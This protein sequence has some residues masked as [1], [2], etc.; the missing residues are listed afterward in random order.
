MGKTLEILN[1]PT[2]NST[3]TGVEE[4]QQPGKSAIEQQGNGDRPSEIPFIEV[5]GPRAPVEASVHVPRANVRPAMSSRAHGAAGPASENGTASRDPVGVIYKPPSSHLPAPGT[6]WNRFAPQLITY[7]QPHHPVSEQYRAVLDGMM[8][9]RVG[10]EPPVFLLVSPVAGLGTT[11]VVLNLAIARAAQ[12]G[13]R[14]L[15]VD[16]NLRKPAVAQQLGL[17]AS[18][19]MRDVL[20][21]TV[22]LARALQE[23][24]QSGLTVL[25][26]GEAIANG[27]PWPTTDAFRSLFAELRGHFDWILV[28]GP[29]WDTGPELVTL[30]GCADAVYLVIRPDMANTPV[31][32]ELTRLISP[33]GS[34]VGGYILTQR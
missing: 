21:R 32:D 33:L 22:S 12:G 16:A 2:S 27:N 17:P 26:A 11:T 30:T 20:G 24:G 18:P 31:A 23:T 28:D 8:L 34:E 14:I 1:K 13:R 15:V 5:G 4:S 29:S 10:C 7:Y 3:A 9:Q 6:A 25:P 19:G